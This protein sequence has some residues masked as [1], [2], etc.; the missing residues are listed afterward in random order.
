MSEFISCCRIKD[1]LRN[2]KL[3]S[4]PFEITWSPLFE[5]IFV[6]AMWSGYIT[7]SEIFGGDGLFLGLCVHISAEFDIV[8]SRITSLIEEEIGKNLKTI[9]FD[10]NLTIYYHLV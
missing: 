6:M 4:F 10:R 1:C 2:K 8:G 3:F 5:F 7:I 9:E